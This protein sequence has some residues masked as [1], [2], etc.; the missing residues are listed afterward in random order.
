[1]IAM[2]DP[3]IGGSCLRDIE[4]LDEALGESGEMTL[5]ALMHGARTP[6]AI[7]IVTGLPFK[8]IMARLRVLTDLLLVTLNL[9]EYFLTEE[10]LRLAQIAAER[11]NS[12]ESTSGDMSSLCATNEDSKARL[13]DSQKKRKVPSGRVLTCQREAAKKRQI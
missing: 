9:E 11:R 5:L 2:D 4:I 10:G 13:G 1:M 8:L 6:H 7:G 12:I 3:A